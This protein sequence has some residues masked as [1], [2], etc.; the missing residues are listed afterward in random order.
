MQELKITRS[1][2]TLLEKETRKCETETGGLLKG[3][4]R[5]PI[6]LQVS[7]AGPLAEMSCTSYRNDRA[8]DKW[9]L[10]REIKQ[11]A[12]KFKLVGYW[13]KH[14]GNLSSPSLTD[15]GVA[16]KLIK[17]NE[18]SDN[19]PIFFVIA[20]VVERE[21]ELHAYSISQGKSDFENVSIQIIED[22][23]EEII[24]A[25]EVEPVITFT[26]TMNFWDDI[27]FRF[28]LTKVGEERIRKEINDLVLSGFDV[29]ARAGGQFSLILRKK[30]EVLC[31][32][33][34][35]YPLN[36]PILIKNGR[37][38][39]YCLPNWNSGYRVMDVLKIIE[40]QRGGQNESPYLGSKYRLRKFT[41]QIR[42]VIKSLRFRKK[43]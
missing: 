13:H 2:Y 31:L 29:E 39:D 6:V 16:R 41:K 27:G 33:P 43:T 24:R 14:P 32:L 3:T 10:H 17:R 18:L 20:N 30:D 9:L 19:A 8:F 1:S 23:S 38:I 35:E 42:G 4:L 5:I 11:N 7:G 15:L 25:L 36:P 37:R 28:Y 40:N 12:G 22:D 26:R 21:F 34:P